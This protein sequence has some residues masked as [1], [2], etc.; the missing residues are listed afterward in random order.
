MFVLKNF[1]NFVLCVNG[2]LKRCSHC[3]DDKCGAC[4]VQLSLKFLKVH[5]SHVF[6]YQ[7]KVNVLNI[8]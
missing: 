1:S 7:A 2:S 5:L 3:D 8:G 4:W 6:V